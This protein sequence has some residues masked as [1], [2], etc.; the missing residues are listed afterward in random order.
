[1]I[2]EFTYCGYLKYD[3]GDDLGNEWKTIKIG[4]YDLFKKI[5]AISELYE[6]DVQI[7]YYVA[8]S[9]QPKHKIM[10]GFLNKLFGSV[11]AVQTASEYHYSEMT[12]GTDYDV[13]FNVGGHC[14]FKELKQYENKYIVMIIRIKVE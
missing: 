1:M 2:K 6:T 12:Y 3:W 5:R 13:D 14:L 10:E 11:E 4:N 7:S 9:E 8:E